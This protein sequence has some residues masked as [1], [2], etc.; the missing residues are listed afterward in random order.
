MG[1]N[2]KYM[3]K[4]VGTPYYI[5]PEIFK[6]KYNKAVDVW[7]CGIIMY[8]LL[9]GM[10]P[11]CGVNDDEIFENIQY[12]ELQF[13]KTFDKNKISS[14]A[15]DLITLMLEKDFKKRISIEDALNHEW[16]D[17]TLNENLALSLNSESCRDTELK[18]VNPIHLKNLLNFRYKSK[19]QEILYKFFVN[20]ITTKKEREVKYFFNSFLGN[21]T[22]ISVIE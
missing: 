16:F 21:L 11:F 8:T 20:Q 5:A 9:S 10:T 4:F 18:N 6:R 7:S 15:R 19:M 3:S 2:K 1:R 12:Q 17:M 14:E 13:N 22:I